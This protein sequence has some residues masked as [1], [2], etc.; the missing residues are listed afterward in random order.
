MTA[1]PEQKHDTFYG[2]K[3]EIHYKILQV[4]QL[5]ADELRMYGAE[6]EMQL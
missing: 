4:T 6:I 1:E 3:V 5:S 2:E